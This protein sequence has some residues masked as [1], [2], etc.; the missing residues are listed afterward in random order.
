MHAT[1]D[2]GAKP[3]R[4]ADAAKYGERRAGGN[5]A[6]ASDDDHRDR[7]IDVVRDQE[8]QG[9]GAEREVDEI[10][11][12]SVS[13]MLDRSTGFLSPLDRLDDLAVARVTTNPLGGNL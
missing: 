4:A 1:L 2:D 3:G 7:R 10:T 12:Q 8:G 6:G 9:G 11:G 5:A 13:E